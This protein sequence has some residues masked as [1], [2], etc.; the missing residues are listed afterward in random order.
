MQQSIVRRTQ[1]PVRMKIT[2]DH[3]YQWQDVKTDTWIRA[4]EVLRK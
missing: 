3:H 2:V 1:Y 4:E